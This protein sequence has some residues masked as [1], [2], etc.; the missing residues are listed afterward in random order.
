MDSSLA[1]VEQLAACRPCVWEEV[2][3]SMCCGPS[4]M[5]ACAGGR[6]LRGGRPSAAPRCIAAAAAVR[7]WCGCPLA[8]HVPQQGKAGLVSAPSS[9]DPPGQWC[10]RQNRAR[11]GW[12]LFMHGGGGGG[13]SESG[14]EGAAGDCFGRQ[15]K[16]AVHLSQAAAVAARRHMASHRSLTTCWL[17][18]CV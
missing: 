5:S 4:C 6:Q 9:Q 15:S 18:K 2:R 16:D 17:L 12:G 11:S 3:V 7:L 1:Q 10:C 13:G 8:R 14:E